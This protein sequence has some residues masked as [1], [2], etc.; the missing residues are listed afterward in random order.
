MIRQKVILG[1]YRFIVDLYKAGEDLVNPTYRT[2]YLFR[3]VD[4][5]S[6]TI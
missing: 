5:I 4:L 6:G 2:F 1:N 3:D